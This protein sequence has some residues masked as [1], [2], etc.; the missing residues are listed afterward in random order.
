LAQLCL[1]KGTKTD[2]E[3]DLRDL[4]T[5]AAPDAAEKARC[6]RRLHLKVSADKAPTS[7]RQST[8]LSEPERIFRGWTTNNDIADC[9]FERRRTCAIEFN[10]RSVAWACG[11]RRLEGEGCVL[12]I[13]G[14]DCTLAEKNFSYSRETVLTLN[15]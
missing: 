10:L 12:K 3:R 1:K 9:R 6:E 4:I 8:A 7:N 5:A 13:N 11:A 14:L 2:E 15:V